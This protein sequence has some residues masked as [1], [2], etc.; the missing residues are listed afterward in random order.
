MSGLKTC[1]VLTFALS[2]TTAAFADETAVR[3]NHPHHWRHSVAAGAIG[4]AKTCPNPNFP[5]GFIS[6]GFDSPDGLSGDDVYGP[7]CGFHGG[8]YRNGV[9]EPGP[10]GPFDRVSGCEPGFSC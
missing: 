2:L 3:A 1:C 6:N 4:V 7:P 5:V 8:L 10:G 9:I